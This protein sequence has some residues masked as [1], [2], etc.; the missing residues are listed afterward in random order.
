MQP[1]QFN[2]VYCLQVHAMVDLSSEFF[3]LIIVDDANDSM[4]YL[5][6]EPMRHSLIVLF[7]IA[8]LFEH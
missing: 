8:E 7:R 5:Y 4:D 6:A 1:M 3:K 2:L